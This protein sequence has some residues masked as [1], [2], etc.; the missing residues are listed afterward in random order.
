MEK[1]LTAYGNAMPTI[2]FDYR[3]VT[4]W[5]FRS[6]FL[7][8]FGINMD[9]AFAQEVQTVAGQNL[10]EISGTVRDDKGLP[11]AGVTITIKG[12]DRATV[13]DAKGQYKIA[14]PSDNSI[15]VFTYIG[16]ALKEQKAGNTPTLDI[17]LTGLDK[18]LNDVIVVGYGK[19]KKATVTGAVEQITSKA[20]E[21]RA[22]T[23]VGLALQGQT[24]GLVVTRG[25]ARPGNE[26][27][28]LQIRGATSI[29][30]GSPL[31]VVDGVPTLNFYNLNAD[32]IESIS[33]IKD[34]ATAIYGSK[35]ANG[36]ILVTTKR[37]AGKL[38]VDYNGNF[39]FTSNGITG[40]SPNMQQYATIWIEANKEETTPNWWGWVS[41]DNMQKM[42]QGIEGIYHT[43]F[44]GDIFIGNANRIEEMFAN[45]FSYQHNLS[46]SNRTENSGYRLS[47]GYSDNQ[48]TLATAYDGQKQYNLRFNHDYKVSNRIKLESGV[49]LISTTT[50]SPSAGLDASLYGQEQPFFPAKNPFG[51]WYAD[52]GTVGDR[53]PVAATTDGGRDN[54][55]ELIGRLDLKGTVQIINNLS[56]EGLISI[57]NKR[58]NQ[59]RWVI[60]VQTYDWYGNKAQKLVT[61]TNTSINPT[62]PTKLN[63]G[64]RTV[65]NT[66]FYQYYSAFLRYNNKTFGAAHN[67]SAAAGIEGTKWNGENLSA[68]RLNFTDLGVQDLNLASNSSMATA[69]GKDVSGTY[70]YIARVN[71]NYAEKYLVELLGRYDGN[72]KFDVGHKFNPYGSALVGWVF[73]KEKLFDNVT[74]VLNF[75]KIRLSYGTAGNDVLKPN[76]NFPYLPIVNQT[77]A[78]VG[79]P[80][81]T[82]TAVNLANNGLITNKLT[83]ESVKQKNAGIDLAFFNNRLSTTF[84]YFIKDN[85]GMLIQV[86]YPSVLGATAPFTND[87]HLRT[88]GWE[89][90]IGWKDAKKDFS[91]NVTFNISNTNNK[92]LKMTNAS[93]YNAGK[94]NTVEGRPMYSWFLFKTD[95]F[96]QSQKEVD[97]YIVQYGPQGGNID[98]VKTGAAILRPGD[99]KKVDI[100]GDNKI[101]SGGNEN[102][103][104]VYMGDGSPHYTFG[105]NLGGSFKGFDL[106]A[107]FQGVG[108]QLIQRNGWLAYP[109]F[110]VSSNQNPTFLGKTWTADHTDAA[111]PRLSTNTSRVAWNYPNNDFMLQKSRYIRLKALIVGYTLPPSITRRAKMDRVR[112]YFSGNDLWELAS[113]RDGYDPE[114]GETSQNVGYPFYRTLSFGINVGL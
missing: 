6:A 43:Q 53:Q 75:G 77:S 50:R 88:K 42:Q 19:Q 24:P 85:V 57:Q 110:S 54:Q 96:F 76:N 109:F 90:V 65:A 30:G 40:Y 81:A 38:K 16:M 14:V 66:E 99:V 60:P 5:F 48:A 92:I 55:K 49:S 18:T 91:Y 41:L 15:L 74:H 100:N 21:S 82:Q 47:L 7:I 11:L 22:V 107:F 70:S 2:H 10:R 62:D 101:T 56:F 103:D 52:Y 94:N 113:I 39:R 27:L 33:V 13:T 4:K 102:S 64:Y 28:N 20:F 32:D 104:L 111:F 93:N 63:P 51:Q 25:S 71:Y 3:H 108:K 80:A 37:G 95:G 83:W 86:N 84:D 69:G 98:P 72:S 87:G 29:N 59:E 67:F 73:T 112:I 23:N 114:M 8:L 46:I 78:V 106:S 26:D 1:K 36:V 68:A 35:G 12:T 45:R 97:D 17:S 9:N 79:V 44:W 58:Y 89:F 105:L 61:A 31:I 34:G